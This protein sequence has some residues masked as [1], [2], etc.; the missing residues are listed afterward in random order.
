[1][2]YTRIAA[3]R[4]ERLGAAIRCELDDVAVDDFDSLPAIAVCLLDGVAEVLVQS[5]PDGP[6]EDL[7][8]RLACVVGYLK[9]SLAVLVPPCKVR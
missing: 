7:E 2:S 3:S 6:A 5:N 4:A 1:M 8:Q 9:A